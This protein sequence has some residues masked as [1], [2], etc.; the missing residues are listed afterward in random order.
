MKGLFIKGCKGCGSLL[1]GLVL[2]LGL[3]AGCQPQRTPQEWFDL[4][5]TGLAGVDAFHIK[6]QAE[7]A[8]LDSSRAQAP[9]TFAY[10]AEL[11]HHTELSVKAVPG[12]QTLSGVGTYTAAEPGKPAVLTL[13]DGSRWVMLQEDKPVTAWT[14]AAAGRVNPLAIIEGLREMKKNVRLEHGAARG[15]LVLRIEPDSEQELLRLKNE[16]VSEMDRTQA[17]WRKQMAGQQGNLKAE[18]VKEGNRLISGSK[19]QLIKLLSTAKV[20]TVYHLTISKQS[21]LPVRLTSE[22]RIT[23]TSSNGKTR[24]ESLWNDAHFANYR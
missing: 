23:Y 10:E 3:L 5:W 22:T 17:L 15:T 19:Q 7:V 14:S 13:Q 2:L 16:L 11:N 4:T 1:V 24:T 8:A 6:G 12:Q 9:Q 21:N 18:A 20:N